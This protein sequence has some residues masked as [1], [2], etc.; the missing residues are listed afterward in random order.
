MSPP[1]TENTMVLCCESATSHG[2]AERTPATV[3]PKPN[4]TNNDGSAQQSSVPTE[5]NNEMYWSPNE[6]V[7]SFC[8]IGNALTS[9]TPIRNETHRASYPWGL[10]ALSLSPPEHHCQY[11]EGQPHCCSRAPGGID[12]C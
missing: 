10:P 11:V 4:K 1:A 5:E 8:S 7:A 6:R 9:P 3:A 12:H 2:A